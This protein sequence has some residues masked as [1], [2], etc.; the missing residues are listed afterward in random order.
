V[1][2]VSESNTA[3][4]G[5]STS[6]FGAHGDSKTNTGVVG[7]SERGFGVHG[8]SRGDN[9]GVVG[10]SEGGGVGVHGLAASNSG[11]R[12]SST[13]GNGGVFESELVAP[14]RLIP[15]AV[16]TPEGTVT[17]SRGELLVTTFRDESGE[18][19]ALWFCARGGDAA[20]TVWEL[21]AGTRP[22][23]GT[24]TAEGMQ[25]TTVKHIQQQLNIVAASGLVFDG[26]FGP[27]TK[28]AVAD[29]QTFQG[30]DVDGVVGP[31][32]WD[33]LFETY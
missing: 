10:S 28:Q 11:V 12:G 29:F 27:I 31:V 33:R 16:A 26:D 32:T 23:P 2:G 25:G 22:Y 8:I 3:V 24:V 21:V 1:H 19:F 13:S 6:G 9:T 18:N 20:S 4:V 7:S 5:F 30:I 14:I 15:K 17:G